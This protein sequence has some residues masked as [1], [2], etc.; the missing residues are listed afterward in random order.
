MLK[1]SNIPKYEILKEANAHGFHIVEI[2]EGHFECVSYT[3]SGVKIEESENGDSAECRFDWTI[4]NG[5]VEEDEKKA[6]GQI[7]GGILMDIIDKQLANNEV[8][9]AGGTD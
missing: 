4:V 7:A 1:M 6:F 8:V 5:Q 2:Q 9:Y 3:Y